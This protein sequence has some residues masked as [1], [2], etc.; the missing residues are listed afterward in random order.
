MRTL[1]VLF[2]SPGLRHAALIDLTAVEYGPQPPVP[3]AVIGFVQNHFG[4]VGVPE[5]G[6]RAIFLPLGL[7][8]VVRRRNFDSRQ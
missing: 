5:T 1:F 7:A 3:T 8:A 2:L 4:P 6:S